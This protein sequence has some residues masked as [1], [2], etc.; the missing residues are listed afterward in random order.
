MYIYIFNQI[1]KN[2]IICTIA[3]IVVCLYEQIYVYRDT[4]IQLAKRWF[5]LT[6]IIEEGCIYQSVPTCD[7]TLLTYQKCYLF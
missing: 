3:N 6:H 7:G 1:V 4:Y 2:I 5:W